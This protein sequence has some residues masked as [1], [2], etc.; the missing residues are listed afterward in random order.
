MKA[1]ELLAPLFTVAFAMASVAFTATAQ[2]NEGG[3][4]YPLAYQSTLTRAEVRAEAT[5]AL[6]A[7]EV[8]RGE[9]GYVAPI[10]GMQKTRA[11]VFAETREAVRLGLV[12][13][14]EVIVTP[15]AVQLAL[16]Q[17]AGLKALDMTVAAR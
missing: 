2:A 16:V 14:G 6:A 10:I 9:A 17:M 12:G 5:R 13:G 8:T 11:Q 3:F 7:G 1:K 15:T 4:E